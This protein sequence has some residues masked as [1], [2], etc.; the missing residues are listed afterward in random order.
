MAV[1]WLT[2]VGRITAEER[3][4][5]SILAMLAV[6]LG[7]V[8]LVASGYLAIRSVA[9]ARTEGE[10][11]VQI[12]M[13]QTADQCAAL[14]A[15]AV[16]QGVTQAEAQGLLQTDLGQLMPPDWTWSIANV[17]VYSQ[18]Q[19][20]QA[21]PPGVEGGVVPGAGIYADVHLVWNVQFVGAVT[22]DLPAFL[23][24]DAFDTQ[25]LQWQGG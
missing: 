21:A 8:F 16:G 9:A 10:R 4:D 1:R 22:I 20:G 24:A 12:A 5:V 23:K 18:A 3:G 7:V 25:T 15:V 13:R 17:Q 14:D 19:A 2:A 6:L 11:F